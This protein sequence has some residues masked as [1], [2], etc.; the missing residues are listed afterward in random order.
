MPIRMKRRDK[1]RDRAPPAVDKGLSTPLGLGQWRVLLAGDQNTASCVDQPY[2]RQAANE[3]G[4]QNE[5]GS[6]FQIMH[7]KPGPVPRVR[8]DHLDG[9]P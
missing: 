8:H 2:Y 7:S 4:R 1:P 6:I 9:L 3:K 5:D